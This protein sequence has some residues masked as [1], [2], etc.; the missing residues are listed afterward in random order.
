MEAVTVPRRRFQTGRVFLRCD[1]WCGSF[2]EYEPNPQ[3]GK[4]A[5]RT[6]TFDESITSKRAAMDA[7][8]PYLDDYNAKA[9][10]SAKPSP[11]APRT[12]KTVSAL[13][14]EWSD[15]ILPNR[16]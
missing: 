13:I 11:P 7:L 15:K 3:T 8:K 14:A 1:R 2:R 6:I 10:A 12:G 4:R 5:R 16:K 9:K